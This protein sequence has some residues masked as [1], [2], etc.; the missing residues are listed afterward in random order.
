MKPKMIFRLNIVST[1]CLSIF[2]CAIS[3]YEIQ[4]HADI[5][6]AALRLSTLNDVTSNGKLVRLG[7]KPVA[8]IDAKQVFPRSPS[9]GEITACYEQRAI[10]GGTVQTVVPL[11]PSKYTLTELMRH[12]A[13]FEDNIDLAGA[14]VASHFY[15][16]QRGGIGLDIPTL[17][18]Q[19][20]APDWAIN[21]GAGTV[22]SGANHFS[23]K[24]ART[25]FYAALTRPTKVE[26]D[27]AWGD[28][29]QIL[30][31]VVHHLQDMAQPQHVRND[32]HCEAIAPCGIPLLSYSPSGYESFAKNPNFGIATIRALAQSATV[33]ILFGLPR[34]FWN[35]TGSESLTNY[36]A[37]NQGIAAYTSTN[38]T[39]AGVD[40]RYVRT[41]ATTGSASPA[42][43]HPMP[44]PTPLPTEITNIG[45][46]TGYSNLDAPGLLNRVCPD[47]SKCTVKFYGSTNQPNTRKSSVSIFGS[48]LRVSS[49]TVTGT[50][51]EFAQNPFTYAAM[52]TDL[53]PKAVEYSAGLI[54][55]F[56][57]GEMAIRVPVEGMYG[58]ID[59]GNPSSNCKDSCGFPKL[60]LRVRNTTAAING[61][62]QNMVGGTLVGVVKYSRNSCYTS[63]WAGDFGELNTGFDKAACLLGSNGEPVEEQ[64]V[65]AP[66]SAPFSLAAGA[67]QQITLDFSTKPLPVNAWNSKLQL[68]YQGTLG[69]EPDA[70]AV[71]TKL[72]SG[73]AVVRIINENNYLQIN[74]RFYTRA[75]VGASQ[76]LLAQ[77]DPPSCVNNV[78]GTL[79]LVASCFVQQPTPRSWQS[80]SGQ[81]LA[82]LTALPADRQ[83][84]LVVLGDSEGVVEGTVV[85]AAGATSGVS[86]YARMFSFND[87]TT[88][89]SPDTLFA[90]R[91][92]QASWVTYTPYFASVDTASPP[93]LEIVNRPALQDPTP[94]PM[95]SINF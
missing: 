51:F 81:T 25:T 19:V 31:H 16:P 92:L 70:V 66:V 54:N 55:Y 1:A 42:P 85:G 74:K 83:A 28:T 23:Y 94:V 22:V 14:R 40:Y 57:R 86:A 77:I 8:L 20:A 73:P 12:G 87:S 3:A 59:G 30:G 29:F 69:A 58:L 90:Y 10:A 89:A 18:T 84:I 15:D 79:T 46:L 75:Q 52:A 71:T 95:T 47:V 56:F 49:T 64:I 34:E 44:A 17:P 80:P 26:R 68:V 62:P 65:S 78:A 60:K 36:A 53:V 93:V 4:N 35:A 61:V 39:S 76:T 33:P 32:A 67:E 50:E 38:F 48:D 27:M 88:M 6:Q 5:T 11:S 82:T 41:S 72:L 7:L 63:N 2:S 43:G 21:G 45:A 24:D 37:A 91:G 9:S 13:C